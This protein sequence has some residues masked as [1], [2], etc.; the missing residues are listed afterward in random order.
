MKLKQKLNPIEL[1]KIIEI[2]DEKTRNLEE[3]YEADE[4]EVIS[5][6][7][8]EVLKELKLRNF[9]LDAE[10]KE[11]VIFAVEGLYQN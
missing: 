4:N 3:M 9:D 11:Q 2:V 6:I 5:F 10:L 8:I 7:V 1:E